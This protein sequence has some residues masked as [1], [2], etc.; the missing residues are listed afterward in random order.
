MNEPEDEKDYFMDLLSL[1]NKETDINEDETGHSL[2]TVENM[3]QEEIEKNAV[4]EILKTIGFNNQVIKEVR[5]SIL[6]GADPEYAEAY[7][8]IAKANSDAIKVLSDI[9]LSKERIKAQKEIKKMDIEGKKEL[10]DHKSSMELGSK[11]NGN[12]F[13]LEMSREEVFDRIL[14]D[15]KKEEKKFKPKKSKKVQDVEVEELD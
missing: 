5:D 1:V 7:A 9:S 6:V 8:K 12:T 13:I 11:S 3:T 14:G 2:D 4:L 10:L 15:K